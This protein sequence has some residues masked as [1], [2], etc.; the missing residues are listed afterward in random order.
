MI[1]LNISHFSFLCRFTEKQGKILRDI[2]KQLESKE[3]Q[4]N[5]DPEPVKKA[6]LLYQSCVDTAATDKLKFSQLFYFLKEYKLP[7]VP[8][9]IS[10]PNGVNFQFDWLRS[11]VKIKRSLGADKL[12][13]LEIFPNPKNRSEKF[14]ALGSPSSEDDLPL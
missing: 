11:I 12:I 13:G 9:L 5:K 4:D 8:S 1:S 7:K 6:R 3:T 14:L 10:D 2:K